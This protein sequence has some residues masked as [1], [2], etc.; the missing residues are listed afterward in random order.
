[1]AKKIVVVYNPEKKQ[2]KWELDLLTKFLR[3]KGVSCAAFRSDSIKRGR[4][5][6]VPRKH[7]GGRPVSYFSR[8]DICITLG[9]D[10]T[11][12]KVAETAAAADVPVLGVNLG[13]LGFLSEF[14][15]HEV[16]DAIGDILKGRF[17]IEKRLLLDVFIGKSKSGLNAVND[18]VIRSGA[19]GRVILLRLR[20]S[21]EPVADYVGDG[22]IIATPVGSTAY[23]LAAGGPII[24]PGLP[25]MTVTPVCPHSLSQRPL[26]LS[27][28]ESLIIE[29]PE[30]KSNREV[31]LSVDGQR[32]FNI[33]PGMEVRVKKSAR[34]LKLITDPRKGYYEILRKKLGWGSVPGKSA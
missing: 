6:A 11:I 7:S 3:D 24:H 16:Y 4:P 23:S 22:L 2:A 25:V 21:G 14:E 9:G 5:F 1:M 32:N 34:C 29:V 19:S 12:L 13:S 30:Y 17:K 31:V 10:G 26:V 28:A 18:C 8:F 20:V 33:V 27:A 15:T